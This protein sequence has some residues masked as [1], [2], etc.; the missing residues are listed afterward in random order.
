[1]KL[2]QLLVHAEIEVA[3]PH[4]ILHDNRH[5]FDVA[6]ASIALAID[7][8]NDAIAIHFGFI[9]DFALFHDLSP[10]EVTVL[11]QLLD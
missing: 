7:Q 5:L 9:A 6:T 8:V 1:M 3:R 2:V 11:V 4:H 10:F